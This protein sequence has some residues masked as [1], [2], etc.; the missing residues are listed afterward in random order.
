VLVAQVVETKLPKRNALI[1]GPCL[2][3]VLE[4]SFGA[5]IHQERG[6]WLQELEEHKLM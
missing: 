2:L 1:G 6:V 4:P 3:M 5:A